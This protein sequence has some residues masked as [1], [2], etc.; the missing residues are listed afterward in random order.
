MVEIFMEQYYFFT[1]SLFV[2]FLSTYLQ[3][4][5]NKILS[6]IKPC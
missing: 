1:F 4:E 5:W 3:T 2:V 6:N